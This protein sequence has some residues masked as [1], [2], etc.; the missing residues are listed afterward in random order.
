M[1]EL[2]PGRRAEIDDL[3]CDETAAAGELRAA[4]RELA[5]EVDRLRIRAAKLTVLLEQA[6]HEA[7]AALARTGGES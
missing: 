1:R 7:S 6:Q 5:D 3:L 4:G 2:P